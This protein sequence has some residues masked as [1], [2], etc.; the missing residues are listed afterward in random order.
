MVSHRL[1][2]AL[3]LLL[4]LAATAA[5]SEELNVVTVTVS[6]HAEAP[7]CVGMDRDQ[8][9]QLAAQAQRAGAHR[10]AAECFRIAGDLAKADREQIR[11][12]QDATAATSQKMAANVETA[13][14]QARRVKDAFR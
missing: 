13:K 14:A 8:A 9:R 12:S 4:G 1:V 10:K 7:Y 5:H 6:A 3:G 11:A 2:L